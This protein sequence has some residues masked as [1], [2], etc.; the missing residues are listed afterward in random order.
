MLNNVVR[1]ILLAL[2]GIGLGGMGIGLLSL[3]RPSVDGST[4]VAATKAPAGPS[5][6]PSRNPK[7]PGASWWPFGEEEA[8][9]TGTASAGQG[10]GERNTARPGSFVNGGRQGGDETQGLTGS[11]EPILGE[12]LSHPPPEPADLQEDQTDP[13]PLLSIS[14]RVLTEAGEPLADIRVQGLATRLF[15]VE[16]EDRGGESAHHT[17]T[18]AQGFY[19]IEKLP[20]GEYELRSEATGRYPAASAMVRAGV[21]GADLV[22]REDRELLVYGLVETTA[23]LRLSGVRVVPISGQSNQAIRTNGAGRYELPLSLS[24]NRPTH[25]LRF[26]RAGYREQ[27]LSLNRA[28]V[29]GVEEVELDVRLQPVEALAEVRGAVLNSTG[30]PVAGAEVLLYSVSLQEDYRAVSGA[31]GGFRLPKVH[32]AGD[33]TLKVR[34]R[35]RDYQDYTESNLR[36]SANGADLE[37]VLAPLEHGSLSG[38]MVDLNGDPVPRF[39]LWMRAVNATTEKELLVT[40]DRAGRFFI[41]KAPR[42]ELSFTTRASPYL[43][44][45]GV[46]LTPGAREPVQLRLDWGDHELF[47]RVLDSGGQPVARSQ[48][49]LSWSYHDNDLQGHSMRTATADANGYFLFTRLGPGRHTLSATA[50]GFQRAEVDYAA[51]SNRGE[52]EIRVQLQ[53]KEDYYKRKRTRTVNNY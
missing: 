27:V 39:S 37:I 53:P 2:F 51:D 21:Q 42:G 49:A 6:E 50:P 1:I 14:G 46:A 10:R 8:V 17:R 28:E 38:Q 24:G 22:V 3:T 36:I 33:Y 4:P 20:D 35:H 32:V 34:P 48:I 45:S 47:G 16:G 15:Q 18:D 5:T 26:L 52:G 12:P 43:A 11:S 7:A 13:A 29:F 19:Q 44:V 9:Q 25:A 30:S 31:F 23:G 41:E 40:G